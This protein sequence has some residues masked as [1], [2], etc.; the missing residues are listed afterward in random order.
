MSM[1][2]EETLLYGTQSVPV[3]ARRTSQRSDSS[4]STALATAI[5]CASMP[6]AS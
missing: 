6:A 5:A 2:A 4:P 1:S 3:R